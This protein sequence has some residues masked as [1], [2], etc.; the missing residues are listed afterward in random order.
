M[1]PATT[2][3]TA[4]L[5]DLSGELEELDAW[6]EEDEL[7]KHLT[8]TKSVEDKYRESQ[9]HIVRESKDW[10]LDYLNIILSTD[11]GTIDLRPTY[12]RRDRWDNKKRS[13]L[14][15]SILMNIPIPPVYLR[16]SDL[17]QYEVIDG[18][19][20]LETI[21]RFLSNQFALRGLEYWFELDG[22][23]FIELPEILR[24]GLLRRSIPV[25]ILL[26]ESKSIPTNDNR[27]IDVKQILFDRLNTGGVK[28]NP[29]ELRNAINGGPF[30]DLLIELSSYDTFTKVWGI[31]SH[32][33]TFG[34]N[35]IIPKELQANTL[36]SQ[37]ADCELVLRFFAIKDAISDDRRGSLKSILDHYMECNRNIGDATIDELRTLFKSSI[38]RLYKIFGNETF[39]LPNLPR[40]SRPLYDALMV[41]AST[42]GKISD[43]SAVK[44]KLER[45]I[46]TDYELLI[47]RGNT[48]G[49]IQDRVRLATSILGE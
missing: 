37:M 28:L 3:S 14:I 9:I 41:A 49:A 17:N 26:T 1:P 32:P 43:P 11:R 8:P 12:Q 40:P 18:R 36:Y 23:T 35:D 19:Q 10:Q 22:K 13:K 16:E 39:R 4:S 45:A 15:E 21:R 44:S 2:T 46:E 24:R 27:S 38:D 25:I 48:I 42:V 31:P 34:D 33:A 47:G 29:Q 20:R 7:D 30:N 6:R 5:T